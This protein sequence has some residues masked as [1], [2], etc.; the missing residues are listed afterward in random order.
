MDDNRDKENAIKH[1]ASEFQVDEYSQFR[2]EK[3]TKQLIKDISDAV[4]YLKQEKELEGERKE[5]NVT[6]ALNSLAIL[7][8]FIFIFSISKKG[9]YESIERLKLYAY[10]LSVILSTIWIGVN[11]E[12][13]SLF[14]ELWKFGIT[15]LTISL[16]FTALVVFSTATAS[17]VINGVFG[18]DSSFFPFTRSFLTAYIFFRHASQLIYLL[19]IVAAFNLLLIGAYLKRLLCDNDELDI[20]WKSLV[21]IFLTLVF[22]YFAWGW[23]GS[24][25]DNDTLNKKVYLLAHQ[26]DFNDKNMCINIKDDNVGVIFLGQNQ[27]QVFVDYNT[28]KPDSFSD[29]IEGSQYYGLQMKDF[30]ILPCLHTES[31]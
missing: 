10:I 6:S 22:S 28:T 27:S 21:F 19:L 4:T 20:P 30:K 13:L 29:F 14:R 26:L 24:N 16:F 3:P 7:A 9:D 17:A 31:L 23:S 11:I 1:L 8:I 25:Y 12:R 2:K 5:W 15:K 18:I